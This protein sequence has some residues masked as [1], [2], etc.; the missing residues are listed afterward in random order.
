MKILLAT[1]SFPPGCGG[2]GWST[3]ELARGLRA[4]G[5]E[6]HVVQPCPGRADG[7]RNYDG[8]R[9]REVGVFAPAVPFARNVLKNERLWTRLA[10]VLHEAIAETGA[11]V[12]HG[13]HVMTI[14]AAVRAAAAAGVPSVATV[15]DYW[16]VC[17]WSDL[18]HDPA[19]TVLCPACSTA[20]M[21]TC[22][23]PRGGLA[24]PLALPLIPY[25]RRNLARKQVALARADRVIAVSSTIGR[26]LRARSSGLEPDRLRVIP[27]PVDVPS[28]RGTAGAHLP[29]R[30][31]PFAIYVGKLARNKGTRHLITA[32]DRAELAWPLVVIG[33]GPERPLVERWRQESSLPITLTGW[34]P[35]E[36]ALG[37]LAAA[38][39][40]IFPSHGP[41]SLSRVL[42][43]AAALGVPIAAM[44]TGGTRDIVIHDRTG[45]L[46]SSPEALGD[47]VARLV[48][49]AG[50]ARRLGDAARAHIEEH[51]SAER[52]VARVESVYREVVGGHA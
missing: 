9:V 31:E 35:R 41:E 2:S 39:V 45:L 34:L 23:R 4:R 44:D 43:E 33:D 19:T 8:F 12:V 46:S 49:D 37:W 48:G 1:D 26:D 38:S 22:V 3:Y 15:R 13:Q 21:T 10:A 30:Q 29:G 40:L 24:W 50:L 14:P 25:M 47:D 5:H 36:E 42:L 16:P 18:I 11:D 52:V 51:F 27:N 6:V 28:I 17:Y 20:A 7:S 32:V